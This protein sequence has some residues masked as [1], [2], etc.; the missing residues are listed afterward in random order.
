MYLPAANTLAWSNNGAETMRLDSSGNLGLGVTP[1]AWYSAYK[2]IELPNAGFLAFAGASGQ[3]TSNA[4]FDGAYKYKT[5]AAATQYAQSLGQHQWFTAPSGTAGNAITFSQVMT[6]D[7]SGNLG[8]GVTPSAWAS[9][10]RALEQTSGG[11]YSY[12]SGATYD[13]GLYNGCYYDGAWKY[14]YNNTSANAYFITAASSGVRHTWRVAPSSGVSGAGT[15]VT[16]T[17]VMVLDSSGNLQ[18]GNTSYAYRVAA[19]RASDGIV[20]Y[21]RRDG[22]TV[23]PALTISCNETGNTVGFGTDYA[24]ATSPAMTFST[25]GTERARITSGG[26]FLFNT[27]S[28]SAAGIATASFQVNNELISMGSLGGIFWEN[29]SGS[30]TSNSNWYGWYT[31]SNVIY[32]YSAASGNVGSINASTGAYTALSDRNKKK[33]FEPSTVGLD[34]VSRLKPTLFRMLGDADD[35]P[36]QLGF[37]AQDVADVIPQAYVEQQVTDAGGKE[38]TYIGLNDRP[39]IAALVKAIQEQQALITSLTARVATLEGTQP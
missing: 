34:A 8:L 37:I 7:A 38:S 9:T 6:L 24:G 5:T 15:A 3:I 16:F 12:N 25:G 13:I 35:A 11:V 28:S 4:Y 26:A 14:K 30:V 18:I 10:I 33:D 23:N 29:R 20:G 36:K 27:T 21:F 31:T 1:S 22:A 32:I 2:A 19:S 39:I 17:D